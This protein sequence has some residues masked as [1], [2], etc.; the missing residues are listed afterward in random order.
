MTE[1]PTPPP[2]F[3]LPVGGDLLEHALALYASQA[4]AYARW[5]AEVA[6]AVFERLE[7]TRDD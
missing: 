3:I 4:E 6:R 7:E 2:P 5:M 1:I